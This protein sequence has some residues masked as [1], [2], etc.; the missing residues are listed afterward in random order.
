MGANGTLSSGIVSRSTLTEYAS[1]IVAD[2]AEESSVTDDRLAEE[3]SFLETLETRN[4]DIS[5]VNID[6]E[7]SELIRIQTAYSAAA[8]MVGELKTMFETLLNAI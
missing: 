8:K 1:S 7:M 6:V 2:H 4:A 5:G 3:E